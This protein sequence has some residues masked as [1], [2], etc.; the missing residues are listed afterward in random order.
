MLE[1][2]LVGVHSAREEAT[3]GGGGFSGNGSVK[4]FVRGD[5][6]KKHESKPHGPNGRRHAG[7]DHSENGGEFVVLIK[8][9]AVEDPN[10]PE[11]Y[12]RYT[13][14]IVTG[15]DDTDDESDYQILV[16]WP[17]RRVTQ[18]GKRTAA[19]SAASKGKGKRATSKKAKSR[20]T[21]RR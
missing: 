5:N 8:R 16:D 13:V 15:S 20:G 1:L 19:A 12:L 10:P 3:M 18:G 6:C 21:R 2:H 17:S 4:W 7:I 14:P 9:P 11:G